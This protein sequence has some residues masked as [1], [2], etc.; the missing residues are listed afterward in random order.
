ME[1]LLNTDTGLC[2]WGAPFSQQA[3]L[4]WEQYSLVVESDGK[5]VKR[6]V[7]V[8]GVVVQ[9]TSSTGFSWVVTQTVSAGTDTHLA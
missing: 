2:Q 9:G 7:V 8:A 4:K 6:E 5:M 3:E 1:L